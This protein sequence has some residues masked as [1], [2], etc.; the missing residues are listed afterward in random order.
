M[1]KQY[2]KT[3]VGM[4]AVILAVAGGVVLW[5]RLLTLALFFFL[6]MQL[7][8]VVGAMWGHRLSEKGRRAGLPRHG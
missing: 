2:R 6:T 5:S 8:A 4:Q 3:F 7:A 1:W